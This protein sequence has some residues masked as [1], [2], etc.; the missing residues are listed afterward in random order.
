MHRK[1]EELD[2]WDPE[3]SNPVIKELDDIITQVRKENELGFR[4]SSPQKHLP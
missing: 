1:A 4:R 2:A 3:M